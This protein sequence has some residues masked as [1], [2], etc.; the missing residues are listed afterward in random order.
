MEYI[1]LST[2]LIVS[3]AASRLNEYTGLSFLTPGSK[4]RALI[5]ILGEE[6]ALQATEF[7]R[8]IGSNFIR[9]ASG[10]MLDFIDEAMGD[11]KQ[12]NNLRFVPA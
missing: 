3:N 8:N 12:L 9:K 7:D 10:K 4:A 2:D 11:G 5:E 1:N 6:L